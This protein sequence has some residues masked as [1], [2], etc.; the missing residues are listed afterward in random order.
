MAEQLSIG[1]LIALGLAPLYRSRGACVPV[2]VMNMLLRDPV[3]SCTM[4]WVRGHGTTL[5]TPRQV[6]LLRTVNSVG[7]VIGVH[8]IVWALTIIPIR[9]NVM[10]R[11]A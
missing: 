11:H 2:T 1:A 10:V 5:L 9:F 7:F 3:C 6:V 8:T 4:L